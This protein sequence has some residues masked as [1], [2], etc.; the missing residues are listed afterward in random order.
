MRDGQVEADPACRSSWL[1]YPGA[2]LRRPKAGKIS[3]PSSSKS[4]AGRRRTEPIL[5]KK[6]ARPV[7]RWGC[8]CARGSVRGAAQRQIASFRQAYCSTSSHEPGHRPSTRS[9]ASAEGALARVFREPSVR[10]RW[11]R[12]VCQ[13][14][15]LARVLAL[16]LLEPGSASIVILV[17]DL[18]EKGLQRLTG[19]P[20]G[21]RRSSC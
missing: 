4:G 5:G 2:D 16:D 11:S 15:D 1:R 19:F 3:L 10:H 8:D 18:G 7:R 20:S 17:L 12:E 13:A 21:C 6:I 14:L 9:A